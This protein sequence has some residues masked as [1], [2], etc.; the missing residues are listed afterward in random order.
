MF[1]QVSLFPLD[2]DGIANITIIITITITITTTT[3]IIIIIIIIFKLISKVGLFQWT[4]MDELEVP[5]DLTPGDYV[6]SFR[7]NL[8]SWLLLLLLL[9]LYCCCRVV[10][11]IIAIVIDTIIEV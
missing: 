6:L 8:F 2:L 9:S 11:V 5:A 1:S 4:L 3:T 10:V 7:S